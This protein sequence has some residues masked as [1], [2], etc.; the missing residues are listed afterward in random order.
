M[1]N[2]GLGKKTKIA[3]MKQLAG[4]RDEELR[5]KP[6][7]RSLFIEMTSRCNEH[8]IHCGSRCGDLPEKDA[9]SAEEIKNFLDKVK[10]DF[11]TDGVSL[12]VTGGE[13]LLRKDFF[14]IMSY[15][16]EL[17]FRWGMTSNA[18]LITKEVAARL[19]KAGMKTISVSVDGLKE[20]H[21][22]FRQTTGSYDRTMDGIRNLV[23]EGGFQHVQITTVVH[24]RNIN[25]LPA[26]LKEFSGL[27]LQSWRVIN[28]EPIGRAKEQPDL[29]LS[30]NEYRQMFEFI[31]SNRN[32]PVLPVTY[33]CSH[34]LGPELEREVREWYFLCNA[35]VYTAS[36]MYNGDIGACLDI[37]RRPELIQGN[38]RR[39]DFGEVWNNRFEIFRSDFRKQG[40]C[41]DCKDYLY[42]AGDSF[43]TWDFDKNEPCICMRD[44]LKTK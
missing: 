31:R 37:E 12:C 2:S 32:H 29:L 40:K 11:G 20:N 6:R 42:C 10:R 43:H 30:P 21:E 27:N 5:R 13:P 33:G 1:N 8:C 41:K 39:D 23:E 38:I 19:H 26:M 44:I 34:F 4:Y 9:L 3:H 15:A 18:T 17:G 16:N 36:I 35:G 22:W 7:L 24:H 28:I 25:E 14:D